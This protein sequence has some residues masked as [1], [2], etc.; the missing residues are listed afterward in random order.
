MAIIMP[1]DAELGQPQGMKSENLFD[2]A[3][4]QPLLRQLGLL[5]VP[6]EASLPLV[7]PNAL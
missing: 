1:S 4:G 6:V 3:Y 7:Y 5:H 2:L